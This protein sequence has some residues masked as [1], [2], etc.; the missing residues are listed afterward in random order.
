MVK[1]IDILKANEGKPPLTAFEYYPP[2]TEE[3]VKNLMKRLSRMQ[4]Q[5]PAYVDFTWGAGGSTSD[6]TLD[7]CVKAKTQFGMEPNMH[8]T[9][10]NMD[11]A[12]I[13]EALEGA[14]KNNIQNIVALRGDPPKGEEEWTATD[15]GFTCALDLVKHIR[16]EHGDFFC[17]SVSGYP[18]GHPTVI[19]EVP[20][21]HTL[22]ESEQKRVVVDRKTGKQSVCLD[23][24]YAKELEYLKAK[25]DAGADF[26]ITQMFFDTST[27]G[28]WVADC[29]AAG[30]TCPIVPGIMCIQAYGGFCRM[31]GFCKSRVPAS[32]WDKLEACTGEDGKVADKLVKVYGQEFGEEVCNDLMKQGAPVLHFYTLNLEKCT[33][34]IL[35]RLDRFV[36]IEENATAA[37]GGKSILAE[38]AE[39]MGKGTILGKSEDSM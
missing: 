15:G 20:E 39:N 22:T 13:T 37:M 3:G 26:I 10:T 7:L 17:V 25:I 34:G 21:G 2:R 11:T 12:K 28:A 36:E 23:A 6:L 27:F 29:R 9:C 19:H 35:K 14:K 24:D 1:I 16:K 30:I 31:T 4:H 38:T 18:E 5:R 33:F 8:L 32:V